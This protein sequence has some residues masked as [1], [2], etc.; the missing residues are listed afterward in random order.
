MMIWLRSGVGNQEDSSSY[1]PISKLSHVKRRSRV[2]GIGLVSVSGVA[3]RSVLVVFFFVLLIAPVLANNLVTGNVSA[4]AQ[5]GSYI[6][7]DPVGTRQTGE[8]ITITAT[9]D[10]PAGSPVLFEVLPTAVSPNR[11]STAG[12]LSGAT[13]TVT[14]NSGKQSNLLGFGV[15]LSTFQPGDYH[16]RASSSNNAVTGSGE[17]TVV[18]ATSRKSPLPV[19][20]FSPNPAIVD[21]PVLFDGSGSADPDGK[22]ISWQW[23]F[24]DGTPLTS[25][26]GSA[27]DAHP[28][29]IYRSAGKYTVGLKVM[30]NSEQFV[31]AYNEVS[32]V[33]PVPPVADFSISPLSGQAY[34]NHPFAVALSDKSTG[35]PR[36]WTWYI[37]NTPVSQ[38]R[39]YSQSI[40]TKPGNY[41]IKLVVT[42]DYGTSAKEMQVTVLPFEP[43]TTVVT[44]TPISQT[45][46]VSSTP[47]GQ[48]AQPGQIPATPVPVYINCDNPCVFFTIPCLWIDILVISIIVIIIFWFAWKHWKRPPLP[49]PAEPNTTEPSEP[50][51]DTEPKGPDEC[52]PPDFRIVTKG[53]ISSRGLDL[54]N[55]DLHLDV[56]S[57]IKHRDKEE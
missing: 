27:D 18:S 15:D 14:V 57:G 44:A 52:Q 24:G 4:I 30:D 6:R 42:N 21:K 45:V 22:I 5:Q 12:G 37:D 20:I 17:F 32:V 16:I 55:P 3:Y 8:K 34:E 35:S 19:F 56:E 1:L 13:G 7:I 47:A 36:T 28:S 9:T 26:T 29:H 54:T 51:K 10:L 48:P 33:V 46:T 38:L 40:F 11:K 50:V 23:D 49:Q 41:T 31:W 39:T 43:T 53:G 25:P 2:R